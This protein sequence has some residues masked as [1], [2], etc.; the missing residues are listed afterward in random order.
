MYDSNFECTYHKAEHSKQEEE[1]RNN[2]LKVF[3]LT[4]FNDEEINKQIRTLFIQVKESEYM[5]QCMSKAAQI[6]L[7]EDELIGF[8]VLFSFDF[9]HLTVPCLHHMLKNST[10]E[11]DEALS[12]LRNKL[13]I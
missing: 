10:K 2:L 4:E 13:F 8:M 5:T 11:Y 6:M 7:S 3:Q 1:Y 9:L 12:H